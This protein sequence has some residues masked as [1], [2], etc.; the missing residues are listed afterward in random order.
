MSLTKIQAVTQIL[1]LNKSQTFQVPALDPSGTG[2]VAKAEKFL[3]FASRRVQGRGWRSNTF[4]ARTITADGS[5][6]IEAGVTAG[7]GD[8]ADQDVLWVRA[9]GA[10]AHRR[11]VLVGSDLYDADRSTFDFGADAEIQVDVVIGYTDWDLIDPMLKELIVAQAAWDYNASEHGERTR[12]L[13][14]ADRIRQ[15]ELTIPR[16]PLPR[17][18]EPINPLPL[19]PFD[20]Q[21]DQAGD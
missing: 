21:G 11:F 15:M 9:G 8:P 6:E 17:N 20:G 19:F 1:L 14:I 5:G 3:D 2:A 12:S 10:D 18:A 4:F 7:F 13:S 16:P